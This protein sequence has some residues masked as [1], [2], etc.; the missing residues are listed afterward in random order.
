MNSSGRC[1]ARKL[2]ALEQREVLA[3]RIERDPNQ[4]PEHG[5]LAVQNGP[6]LL[7]AAD[8]QVGNWESWQTLEWKLD[9]GTRVTGPDLLKR[10]VFYKVGHHGSGNATPKAVVDMMAKAKHK[11]PAMCSTQQGVYGKENIMNP[12]AGTALRSQP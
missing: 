12:S 9:D 11:F 3:D 5:L 6:P 7:F 2:A 10:T 4:F 1:R 8:A